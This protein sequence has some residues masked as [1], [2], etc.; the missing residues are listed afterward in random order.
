MTAS[1]GDAHLWAVRS[2]SVGDIRVDSVD[3][4]PDARQLE[5]ACQALA[6]R[7]LEFTIGAR[8]RLAQTGAALARAVAGGGGAVVLEL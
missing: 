3:V 4:R 1:G 8:F 6:A 5:L 7:K 2:R